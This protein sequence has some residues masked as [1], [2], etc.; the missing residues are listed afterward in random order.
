MA[1]KASPLGSTP[2][3]ARTA[4]APASSSARQKVS[5]L[6]MDWMVKGR[7]ASPTLNWCPSAVA[8][9]MP[10]LSGSIRASSGM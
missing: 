1:L 9:A 10:K 4:A 7:S 3:R 2:T 5:A 6:E 8:M